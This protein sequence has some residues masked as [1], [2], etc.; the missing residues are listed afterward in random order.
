MIPFY[1]MGAGEPVIGTAI[2]L[3]YLIAIE[4]QREKYSISENKSTYYPVIAALMILFAV[5]LITTIGGRA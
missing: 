4:L 1:G 3:M 2:I 5:I